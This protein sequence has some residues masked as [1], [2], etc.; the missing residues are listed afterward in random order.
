MSLSS[1]AGNGVDIALT[2]RSDCSVAL[3]AEPVDR[4][5][6][7]SASMAKCDGIFVRLSVLSQRAAYSAIAS[8]GGG[9]AMMSRLSL[10][11]VIRQ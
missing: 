11:D 8:L 9:S 5:A 1:L 3:L 4:V 7:A 2:S 10:V 6:V